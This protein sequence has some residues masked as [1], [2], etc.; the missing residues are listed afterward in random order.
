MKKAT[1]APSD[2][3]VISPLNEEMAPERDLTQER[4]DRVIP[5]ARELLARL[6]ARGEIPMGTHAAKDD[7][8][9]AEWLSAVFQLDVVP[10]LKEHNLRYVDVSY[11]FSVLFQAFSLIKEVT[12]ASLDMSREIAMARKWDVKDSDE[13]TINQLDA[14][15]LETH[16][17]NTSDD[18]QGENVVDSGDNTP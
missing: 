10:L 14:Y 3:P 6:V 7:A 12:E 11:L 9:T 13:V 1:P 17:D 4:D 16:P 8:E 15:L 18:V 2:E 5:V